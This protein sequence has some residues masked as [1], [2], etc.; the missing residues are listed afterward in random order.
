M[1]IVCLCSMR[2]HTV[3]LEH[4]SDEFE[5]LQHFIAKIVEGQGFKTRRIRVDTSG[6][7]TSKYLA[8]KG[9]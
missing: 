2:R 7:Q 8:A 9:I 6:E 1:I 4:K 3:A 5:A